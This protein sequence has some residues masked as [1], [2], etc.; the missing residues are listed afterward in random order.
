MT[1]G[2][3]S[4]NDKDMFS[5]PFFWNTLSDLDQDRQMHLGSASHLRLVSYLQELSVDGFAKILAYLQAFE[6]EESN[7]YNSV[8]DKHGNRGV[9][10]KPAQLLSKVS[11]QI[12]QKSQQNLRAMEFC[13]Q[14][15]S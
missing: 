10:G 3:A 13:S 1:S 9:E 2:A 4:V 12:T 11:D 15:C 14:P 6:S 5:Y 8:Y 7:A